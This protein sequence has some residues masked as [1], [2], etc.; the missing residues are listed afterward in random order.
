MTQNQNSGAQWIACQIGARENYAVPRALHQRE[1]L[2]ELITDLWSTPHSRTFTR[3]K[4]DDRYHPDLDTARVRS[5][6]LSFLKL[7]VLAR[8]AGLRD[9]NLIAKRNRLFQD[10]VVNEC[11][12]INGTPREPKV[13]AYSYAAKRVLKFA[14]QRSWPTVLGQID[15]GLIEERIVSTLVDQ[16]RDRFGW[17]PAP[18]WYWDDWREECELADRVMVNSSWSRSCL[19]QA[20]VDENKINV[21]PLAFESPKDSQSFVRSYPKHFNRERPLRVLFLG[22]IKERKG[23]GELFGAIRA[24]AGEPVEFWLVGPAHRSVQDEIAALPQVRFFGPVPRTQ[25]GNYYRDTDVFLFPT[26]SDGFGLTQ[27]E[28]QA[29]KLPVVA[30]THCGDVVRDGENGLLLHEVEADVIADTVKRLLEK[31]ELLEQLSANSAVAQQ[32]SVD[33]LAESITNL[34]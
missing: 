1:C 21:I 11:T 30:S 19:I 14:K 6:N 27:L 31:P 16:A 28:A 24:L 7:E 26:H 20:G 25:V 15:A 9:W 17:K 23:I 5:A 32:F 29:W 22:Q 3:S 34:I 8:T 2:H 4:L 33:A 18:V 10:F 12:R 13:F